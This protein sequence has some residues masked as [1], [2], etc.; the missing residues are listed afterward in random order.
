MKRTGY[1]SADLRKI[2]KAKRKGETVAQAA[3]RLERKGEVEYRAFV[4][5]KKRLLS[6]AGVKA[7]IRQRGYQSTSDVADEVERMVIVMLDSAIKA[8]KINKRKTVKAVDVRG[9]SL[10][11]G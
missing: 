9:D 2:L 10:A 7:Y 3:K 4:Q 6:T 1:T 8:A 11:I 5:P